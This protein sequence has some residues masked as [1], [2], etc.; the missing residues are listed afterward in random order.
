MTKDKKQKIR[1]DI[2]KTLALHNPA[3][4]FK[5]LTTLQSISAKCCMDCRVMMVTRQKREPGASLD[6]KLFCPKCKPMVEEKSK[7]LMEILE[8]ARK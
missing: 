5:F 8:G 7:K 6:P 4:W 2:Y 1:E 3:A